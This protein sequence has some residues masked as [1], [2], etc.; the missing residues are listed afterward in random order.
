MRLKPVIGVLLG[1]LLLGT[2]GRLDA[3]TF[4]ISGTAG[5]YGEIYKMQ[6]REARRDP[7]R[8]QVYI[9][10]VVTVFNMAFP[11]EIMVSTEETRFRQPFNRF[12]INPRWRWVTFHA[13]DFNARLNSYISGVHIRGGGID[14]EPRFFHINFVAGRSQKA[15]PNSYFKRNLW[16]VQ[17]GIGRRTGTHW[18]VALLHAVDDSS[19]IAATD[20]L[21]PQ[22]NLLVTTEFELRLFRGKFRIGAEGAGSLHSLDE[23]SASLDTLAKDQIPES[24]QGVYNTIST[25]FTPRLSTRADYSYKLAGTLRLRRASFQ[26]RYAWFGP[27]FMS[28]G[29]PYMVNDRTQFNV[30]S[31]VQVIPRRVT[32]SARFNSYHD[33]LRDSKSVTNSRNYWQTGLN[34]RPLEST[35][36]TLSYGKGT[37]IK[38]DS[39]RVTFEGTRLSSEVWQRFSLFGRRQTARLA[40]SYQNSKQWRGEYDATNA[41]LRLDSEWSSHLRGG[42]SAGTALTTFRGE[43]VQVSIFG[44]QF[45]HQGFRRKLST[46]FSTSFRNGKGYHSLSTQLSSRLNLT[47]ADGIRLGFRRLDYVRPSGTF[48]ESIASVSVDHRF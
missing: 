9:R 32:F 35:G 24:Y 28:F 34:L 22:E 43:K 11:F 47:R 40:Y 45:R 16:A 39:M 26:A 37:R 25:I 7:T 30:N 2:G 14:L 41:T 8:G 5:T 6:G 42:I 21:T 33:N 1:L 31:R 17:M 19:S 46:S 4:R 38:E 10:P 15:V 18:S 48:H 13:G 36:V 44:L 27:G 12:G 3:Q 20:N 23:R 29:V